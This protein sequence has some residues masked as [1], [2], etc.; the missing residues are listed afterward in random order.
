MSGHASEYIYPLTI[1][2]TA[3]IA[4]MHVLYTHAQNAHCYTNY[5]T[6]I[7]ALYAHMG[8]LVCTSFSNNA[9]DC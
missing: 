7:V 9:N 6:N 2:H 8:V 5:N 3:M 4:C 1:L